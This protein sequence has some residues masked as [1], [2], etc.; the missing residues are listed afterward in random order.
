[1]SLASPTARN[2]GS[3]SMRS[4][5]FITSHARVL[6]AIGQD[7]E[8]RV[9]QIAREAGVTERSV[10]RIVADLV[11]AG[12]VRRRRVGTHNLYELDADRPLGDPVVEDQRTRDLLS[13]LGRASSR[14]AP[15][16]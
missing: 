10:Y 13:L 14:A 6:L 9:D 7:P 15:T 11:E 3:S 8:L 5:T 16:R 1:M 12:Y 2:L 4:W